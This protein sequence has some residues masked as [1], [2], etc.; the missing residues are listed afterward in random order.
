MRLAMT[1]LRWDKAKINQ[2]LARQGADPDELLARR[3]GLADET[4]RWVKHM[5][6]IIAARKRKA[7]SAPPL[8]IEPDTRTTPPRKSG[9]L[10]DRTRAKDGKW[11][12]TVGDEAMARNLGLEENT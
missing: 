10:L 12:Y 11:I 9:V 2:R 3:H 6:P 7:Q 5:G 1:A 4:R 8:V